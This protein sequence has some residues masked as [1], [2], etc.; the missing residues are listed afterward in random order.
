M[1]RP[2]I[3][4]IDLAALKYNLAI[5]RRHAPR[6]KVFA[7]VKANAY[8]HGLERAARA[9]AEAEGL[10][11]LELDAAVALR[12]AGCRQR[13]LLL[14]GFFDAS[15]LPVLTRHRIATVVHGR[16][17]LDMLRQLPGNAAL[18]VFVKINTGM[19]RLGF[20][21]EEFPDALRTLESHPGVA[22]VTL[23]THFASADEPRGVQWQMEV[24]DR[25]AN[26]VKLPGSLAN[27]AA[28]LRYPETHRDWVRPGIMLYGCSPF[29]ERSGADIGLRPAMTLESRVIAV[30]ELKRGDTVGYGGL[31]TAKR[32]TRA[33]VVA[34]GYADGYPRHAPT[35]TP[36]MVGGRMTRTLGRVSMDLLC[37]DLSG[38]PEATA[39]SRVVLWGEGVPV[40]RVAAAAG[41]VGY[42]LLCAL[43]PRVRIV[44]I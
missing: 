20:A 38:I 43:A 12:E 11:L 4:T 32:D 8:G 6:S 34:C 33:G 24:Y 22:G 10:A 19:N 35:G 42:Q 16:E 41:T 13:L 27:S 37:A 28:V 18:D 5:V 14:E 23:M 9:L 25:L 7:V 21:P 3:A 40:E 2:L 31:F 39:G 44:E 26:G 15:E 17:Q 29:A 36:I 30:R 1:I